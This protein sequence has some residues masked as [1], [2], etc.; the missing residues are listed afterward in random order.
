LLKSLLHHGYVEPGRVEDMLV[1]WNSC[2]EIGVFG[3]LD[4]EEHEA[5]RFDLKLG[6]I[7]TARWYTCVLAITCKQL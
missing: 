7:G 3:Q 6:K 5:A 4:Y 2:C 1:G